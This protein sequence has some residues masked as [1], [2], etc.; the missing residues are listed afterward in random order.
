MWFV[1][2]CDLLICF[3]G[4]LLLLIVTGGLICFCSISSVVNCRYCD[5]TLIIVLFAYLILRLF[6]MRCLL[7]LLVWILFCWWYVVVFCCCFVVFWWCLVLLLWV[8]YLCSKI[9]YFIMTCL[10]D[11]GL[12]CVYFEFN[13]L[14]YVDWFIVYSW[15]LFLVWLVNLAFV[16]D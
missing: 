14:I 9:D 16:H 8:V 3:I 5:L 11:C 2:G 15:C 4:E 7:C 13:L 1:W 10:I 12:Y 6:D